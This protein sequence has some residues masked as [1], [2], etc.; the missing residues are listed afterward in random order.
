MPT[1]TRNKTPA[2]SNAQPLCFKAYHEGKNPKGIMLRAEPSG[3]KNQYQE[4]AINASIGNQIIA[5]I[6]I[7]LDEKGNL[8]ILCTADSH[9]DEHAISIF[10]ETSTKKMI[11]KGTASFDNVI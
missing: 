1:K 10:P 5:D 7:G 6:L 3:T 8:R 4:I 11:K 2:F 9:V